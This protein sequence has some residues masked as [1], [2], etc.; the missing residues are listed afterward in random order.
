MTPTHWLAHLCRPRRAWRNVEWAHR[1]GWSALL[2]EQE[3]RNPVRQLPVAV[4]KWRW[5]RDHDNGQS[6]AR[7]VFVLGAQRS[8]TNMLLRGLRTSPEFDVLHEGDRRVFT[9][10]RLRPD[11]AVRALVDGSAHRYVVVKPLCDSHRAVH[12]LD[13]LGTQE[14]GI[15]L[16]AYR[17]VDD[18]VRSAVRKFGDSNL[19]VQRAFL[20]DRLVG[21]WQL[22]G[23]SR[24]RLALLD[25]FDLGQATP[26]TGAALFWL[27]RNGL[28]LDLELDRRDDVLPVSYDALVTEPEATMRAVCAFLGC[29]FKP[30]FIAH[31]RVQPPRPPRP[32][33][34][35]SDLRARCRAL[36][37]RLD[38]CSRERTA[39]LVA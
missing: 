23:L 32:V 12:L 1:A 5:R 37:E 19:R 26:E 11:T 13:G 14:R 10:F 18:R 21:H 15:A 17:N 7:P 3:H 28:Y 4:A 8:G 39:S 2:E 29:R 20:A 35:D 38:R 16:W 36:V 31:I 25:E 34:I 27:L 6:G 22:G 24:E 33:T 9:N 30:S